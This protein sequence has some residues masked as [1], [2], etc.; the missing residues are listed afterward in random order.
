MRFAPA[1]PCAGLAG[2]F[3]WLLTGCSP[4]T[5]YRYSALTPAAHPL[6]WDGRIATEGRL[7]V[8][9]TVTRDAVETNLFPVL[10]DTALHVP[11]ATVEGAAT[12]AI[13]RDVE[14]GV[15]Y[16]YASYAWSQTSAVGTPPLPDHPSISGFGPE[17]RI[18]IP[19][20]KRRRVTLGLG[21]N[22]MSYSTPYAEWQRCPCAPGSNVFV[23]TSGV[24]DN[25]AYG[26]INQGSETHWATNL[27]IY[28]AVNL[29]DDGR[30]GHIFGGLSAH[31]AF[32]NDGFTNVD[33]SGSTVESA[34][35]LYFLTL[36]YGVEVAPLRVSA[37]VAL[38]L[39]DAGSAVNY[40][41]AGF[42][43][44][45]L[46]IPLWEGQDEKNRDRQREND[47]RD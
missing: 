28:P 37:L 1:L 10:H 26:L 44:I 13:A 12:L 20:D 41:V 24:G 17:I 21:G 40:A 8:E 25:A 33:Q 29:S 4:T 23:D 9:G 5:T 43:S 31:T 45:G 14:L 34:G 6:S 38:P 7:R 11:L 35:L 3:A 18:A 39:A 22:L 19:L 42:L 47:G 36:G 2:L 32:K 16:S 27:A 15:R 30:A 46:D